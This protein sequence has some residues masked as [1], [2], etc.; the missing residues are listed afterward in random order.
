MY[1][2]VRKGNIEIK[3]IMCNIEG[4][5]EIKRVMQLVVF[6]KDF[7]RKSISSFDLGGVRELSFLY[8]KSLTLVIG[9]TL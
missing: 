2:I 7:L 5:L 3:R 1:Y 4:N 9:N 6:G 8:S